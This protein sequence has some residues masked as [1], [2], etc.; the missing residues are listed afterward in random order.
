MRR[1]TLWAI[2]ISVLGLLHSS[3]AIAG[4]TLEASIQR[5]GATSLHLETAVGD[6]TISPATGEGI[7]VVVQLI[8]RKAGFFSSLKEAERQVESASLA[9]KR[10]GKRI[11]VEIEDFAGE[12]RFEARWTVTVPADLALKLDVGVGNLKIRGIAGGVQV[13]LGVGD[14]SIE[15]AGGEI[16]ADVGVGDVTVTAPAAAYGPVEC[17]TGVGEATI[18]VNAEAHE[19]KGMISKELTWRG[20]G[21]RSINLETGVGS[22]IVTLSGPSGAKQ[23]DGD[24]TS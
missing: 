20:P 11:D 18:N 13:D 23:A 22:I 24:E 16:T 10:H 19:G 12:P 2:L 8:P 9:I 1:T 5:K 21:E 17:S 4:R 6:V 3:T 7:H 14:A 15:T